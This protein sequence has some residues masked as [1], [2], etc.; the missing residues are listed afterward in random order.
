MLAG[1]RVTQQPVVADVIALPDAEATEDFGRKLAGRLRWGDVVALYGDL[2]A[3][4]TTLARGLLAGLGFTGDVAS[5]TFP[6]VQAYDD[7]PI[8]LWHVDLYR[9]EDAREIDELALDEALL[10]GAL[11]IE[12]PERLGDALW[13]HALRLHLTS[14]DE[15]SRVL[16]AHVPPAWEGR[17]PPQ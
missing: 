10:D 6:I 16:T 1:R 12:W 2:G 17:W 9:I 11:V 8:P 14:A 4:K 5:P 3:G 13:P 15:G 7:L